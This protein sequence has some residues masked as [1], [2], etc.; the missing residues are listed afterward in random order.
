MV[1]PQ[2]L[3]KASLNS[4]KLPEHRERDLGT[5]KSRMHQEVEEVLVV[6]HAHAVAYPGAVVVHAKDAPV[7]DR[8]VMTPGGPDGAALLA[9]APEDERP[10]HV[11]EPL[12][13]VVL[14]LQPF[15]LSHV[16]DSLFKLSQ[17]IHVNLVD[18]LRAA[19]RGLRSWLCLRAKIF[20][21]DTF[22]AIIS[23]R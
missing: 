13:H 23:S 6:L 11:G 18:L 15:I 9:V 8:A 7:A 2:K 20:H 3:L 22:L 17:L 5:S 4:R 19:R 1:L 12:Q 21:L 14:D 10:R 16:V